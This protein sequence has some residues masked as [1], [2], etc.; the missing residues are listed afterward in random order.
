MTDPFG[1]GVFA[2]SGELRSLGPYRLLGQLATGGMGVVYLGRDPGSGR[3]A[4]VKTLLAPGGVSEEARKRFNRE[5]KLAHRVT[6]SYTARVLDSDVDAGR[7]WMA[8]EYV[9]APSLEA[10]VVQKGPLTDQRAVR[11]I[12]SGVV[13]ALAELHDKG[14][15]HR[16]VK[17]LNILLCSDGPKVIDFGISHASDLTSTKLTLGTIAFAAPEQAQGHPSTPASDIYALGV[18]LYYVACGKL[19]YPETSEP[20]Q[21]LN[22]VRQ[23]AIDLDGLPA[24]L[25]EVV[26]DCLAAR[27]DDRL[28][29]EQLIRRFES[30]TSRTLSA[31]WT[32]LVAQY[33]EE[34]RRLQRAADQAEA[35]TVTRS[36]T[37]GPGGTRHLTEEDRQ[38]GV[39]KSG[40]PDPDGPG[41]KPETGPESATAN[42]QG[43]GRQSP[44]S[45]PKPPDTAPGGST[46]PSIGPGETTPR[47]VGW[48]NEYLYA[49]L[50]VAALVVSLVINFHGN[51]SNN[52]PD[53]SRTHTS[54]PDDSGGVEDSPTPSGP[55]PTPPSPQ[56]EAFAG[57]SI[58]DCLDNYNNPDGAWSPKTPHAAS[59]TG[60]GS[61]Y[62]VMS[63][64]HD[65]ASCSDTYD[66]RWSH[67]NDNGTKI[68]FCLNRN[69]RVGQC[70]F[71]DKKEALQRN[72][73]TPCDGH[74]PDKYK[75]IVRIT[76]VYSN[77]DDCGDQDFWQIDDHGIALCGKEIRQAS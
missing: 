26:G 11:W 69:F 64:V 70:E 28:T 25:D 30:G 1:M 16:D 60:T 29:A 53:P 3:I 41:L 12:A 45:K 71:A 51:H 22:Y 19:P 74:I 61:Y 59:C 38:D 9:P 6:S 52:S 4:A 10:L 8:M 67:D 14:I 46:P 58:D 24:G 50:G 5:V 77:K 40:R 42:G 54:S 31:G 33:A 37:V 21:Q 43:S 36:W 75:Y 34:G 63:I 13:R 55:E 47:R 73:I 35:E 56:D 23:A 18:T 20:L 32:S 7:P 62:R 17:P 48:K 65:S 2:L 27:P 49:L 44:D 72:Q 68:A 57:I 39:R 15:V 66:Y 76:G